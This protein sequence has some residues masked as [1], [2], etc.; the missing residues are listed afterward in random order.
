MITQ[1]FAMAAQTDDVAMMVEQRAG[2]FEIGAGCPWLRNR[3]GA[4]TASRDIHI[5]G[6]T[7]TGTERSACSRAGCW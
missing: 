4:T 2:E 5:R 3:V 7:I 6:R 1:W